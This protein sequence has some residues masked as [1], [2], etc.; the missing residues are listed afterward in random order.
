M[1]TKLEDMPTSQLLATLNI[2]DNLH[3]THGQI[4]N[5]A[6][7]YVQKGIPANV[8]QKVVD[9]AMKARAEALKNAE[10]IQREIDTRLKRDFDVIF[11]I[12]RSQVIMQEFEDVVLNYG[13]E[14][15][16]ELGQEY[17]KLD[18][19]DHAESSEA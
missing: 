2:F 14:K 3:Q 12:R 17:K 1:K 19:S 10:D 5:T 8:L 4:I 11:G 13:Q 6:N 16:K 7:D 15:M 9:K 18:T